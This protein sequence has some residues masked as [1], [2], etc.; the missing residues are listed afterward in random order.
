ME[1]GE[2]GVKGIGPE[3]REFLCW[4]EGQ[5][6]GFE[7]LGK[8][9]LASAD[10]DIVTA[11]DHDVASDVLEL[12]LM[13]GQGTDIPIGHGHEQVDI[14]LF[15]EFL[16]LAEVAKSSGVGRRERFVGD[17]HGRREVGDFRDQ[18]VSL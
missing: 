16:E 10:I 18:G 9:E 6:L 5:V 1:F 8:R 12:L 13:A 4:N 15:D 2:A 3:V 11:S 17:G 14:V 7:E